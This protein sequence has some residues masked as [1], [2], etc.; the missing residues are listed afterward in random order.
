MIIINDKGNDCIKFDS[1]CSI[2]IYTNGLKIMAVINGM[3]NRDKT[4]GE[5]KTKEKCRRA[6]WDLIRAIERGEYLHQVL[7]DSAPILNTNLKAKGNDKKF[8]NK[9]NGKTK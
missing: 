2:N 5:Y 6:F 7:D 4:L 3:Q 1:I 9:T 8:L